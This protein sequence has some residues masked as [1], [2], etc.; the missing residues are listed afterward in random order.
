MSGS[1][2][3]RSSA[4]LAPP[5]L[6]SPLALFP[7]SVESVCMTKLI[8]DVQ[9]AELENLQARSPEERNGV[10]WALR[11]NRQALEFATEG[12]EFDAYGQFM[13]VEAIMTAIRNGRHKAEFGLFWRT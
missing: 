7:A 5:F 6:S 3:S 2:L 8:F 9:K 12:R 11:L 10:A 13:F 4:R 1:A